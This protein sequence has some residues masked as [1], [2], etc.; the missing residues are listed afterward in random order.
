M[1]CRRRRCV[2]CGCCGSGADGVP[3][4][5]GQLRLVVA[6]RL[7]GWAYC[8]AVVREPR[9]RDLLPKKLHELPSRRN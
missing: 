2:G 5:V 9:S 1:I 7:R 8:G 6:G 4:A 3:A